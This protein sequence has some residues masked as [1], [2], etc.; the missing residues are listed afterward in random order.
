MFLTKYPDVNEEGL[1]ARLRM[2]APS[3][4]C[5]EANKRIKDSIDTGHLSTHFA[6]VIWLQYN[7][8][9]SRN[10]LPNRFD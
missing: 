3:S 9:R 7:K 8:S 2:Y 4:L 1:I 5:A 6:K 10:R